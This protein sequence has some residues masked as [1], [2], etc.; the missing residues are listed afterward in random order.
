MSQPDRLKCRDFSR[1]NVAIWSALTPSDVTLLCCHRFVDVHCPVCSE[2]CL[3]VMFWCV[4]RLSNI[5]R[6][7]DSHHRFMLALVA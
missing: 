1:L 2:A 6:V 5:A 7:S 4:R 3:H